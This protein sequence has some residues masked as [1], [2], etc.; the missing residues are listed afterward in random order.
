MKLV[1][2]VCLSFKVNIL[3]LKQLATNPS[4]KRLI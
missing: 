4:A 1:F 3:Q 2:Q